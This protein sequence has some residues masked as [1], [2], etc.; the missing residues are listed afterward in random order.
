[1][2]PN[3]KYI[4]MNFTKRFSKTLQSVSLFGMIASAGFSQAQT[5]S[6]VGFPSNGVFDTDTLNGKLYV[7]Q[8]ADIGFLEYDG[9]T[10]T[11]ISD[12]NNNL[13][14]QH[15][16]KS[17]IKNI[18]GTLYLGAYEFNTSGLGDVHT[19][20]GTTVSL[21]QNSTFTY[22]GSYRFTNFGEYNGTIYAGGNFEVPNGGI[23]NGFAKWDGSD[24]VSAT[25]PEIA[26]NML[27]SGISKMLNFQNKFYL[28]SYNTFIYDGTNWDS[29]TFVTNGTFNGNPF[30]YTSKFTDAVLMN[31]EIYGIGDFISQSG[32]TYVQS[33]I[34]KWDGTTLTGITHP[35]NAINRI[36]SDGPYIYCFAELTPQG[37]IYLVRY[38]GTQWVNLAFLHTGTGG[39]VP[40]ISALYDY[41]RIF[42][43]NGEIYVG[44]RFAEIGG[45]TIQSLAKLSSLP[46]NLPPAAPSNL[47][48]TV[49]K[50]EAGN[51]QLS[52]TDNANNEDG[53]IIERSIDAGNNF[54]SIDS[55]AADIVVFDDLS[56]TP[57]TDYVYK[58]V[59]YNAYGNSGAS[60]QVSINTGTVGMEENEIKVS[61][62][63]NPSD[64]RIVI[65]SNK[66]VA[67]AELYSVIGEMVICKK[68]NTPNES[69]DISGLPQGLYELK[70]VS[71]NGQEVLKQRVI[72]K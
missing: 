35:Y 19:Y 45:N 25:P 11:T 26:G 31:N 16:S 64:G 9:T 13:N 5:W 48:A 59:A 65:S 69:I 71:P 43:Y 72:K 60:N 68:I 66:S 7:A 62:Y 8:G 42:S 22:N 67:K 23:G 36:Y 53:F 29:T 46:T 15:K 44:G 33:S 21:F 10:W 70:V 40:G 51:V 55:V 28:L 50:T 3:F 56:T 1:M 34:A 4:K 17:A 30:S 58:V 49:F 61:V 24:W 38:D 32:G 20:D 6:D 41:N 57:A 52:W 18:N 54:T 2:R 63:P 27:Y 12:Y 37:D 39:V 14:T 47:T